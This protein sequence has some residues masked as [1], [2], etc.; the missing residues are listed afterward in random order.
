MDLVRKTVTTT[1]VKMKEDDPNCYITIVTVE[2]YINNPP[3]SWI[4]VSKGDKYMGG[5]YSNTSA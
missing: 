3:S 4:P 2:E 5:D 1:E